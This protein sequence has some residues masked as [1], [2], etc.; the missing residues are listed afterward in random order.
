L[1]FEIDK[2][3]ENEIQR[4]VWFDGEEEARTEA[5]EDR[6]EEMKSDQDATEVL[7]RTDSESAESSDDSSDEEWQ[8]KFEETKRVTEEQW[9]PFELDPGD[10]FAEPHSEEWNKAHFLLSRYHIELLRRVDKQ[11]L[12]PD[13]IKY[14]I[15][16]TPLSTNTELSESSRLILIDL[17]F[18]CSFDECEIRELHNN[19]D[20]RPPELLLGLPCTHKADIFSLGLLL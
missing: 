12:Q 7:S 3:S 10:K 1:G 6:K 14:T 19:S 18:S 2:L 11:P 20:F 13:G 17:G 15:Y 16:P 4:A 5:E 8:R 9:K